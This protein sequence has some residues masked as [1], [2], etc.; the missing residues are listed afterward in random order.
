M[1][2]TWC[3][4][5]PNSSPLP[6]GQATSEIILILKQP[7]TTGSMKIEFT[8]SIKL[9]SAELKYIY[10]MPSYT[11]A[12][13]TLS[14][15]TR[16]ESSADWM[17]G[18]DMI[19]IHIWK[20]TSQ[21]SHLAKSS[22]LSGMVLQFLWEDLLLNKFINKIINTLQKQFWIKENKL[23]SVLL[24]ILKCWCAQ[25]YALIWVAFQFLT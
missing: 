24:E 11:Q 21:N 15:S 3:P 22:K 19:E 7:S 4:K 1:V 18:Q 2:P 12:C 17:D 10:S 9:T 6:Q 13:S 8:T 23:S 25:L 20:L 16:L 5:R 14:D